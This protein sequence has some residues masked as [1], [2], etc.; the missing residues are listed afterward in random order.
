[1]WVQGSASLA[2]LLVLVWTCREFG[3]GGFGFSAGVFGGFAY[4]VSWLS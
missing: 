1:M 3:L 4:L 2:S